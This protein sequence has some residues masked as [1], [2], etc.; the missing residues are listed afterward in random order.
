ML[1]RTMRGRRSRGRVALGAV[2]MLGGFEIRRR[3]WRVVVF[4]VLV[5][6]V[7]AVVLSSVAGARRSESALRR[8]SAYSR[9][10]ELELTV[11]GPTRAQLRA[12][13]GVEGVHSF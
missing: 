6:V 3:G 9:A 7:G 13:R 1:L 12:F 2:R 10:A 4:T 11:G 5:G 8:F